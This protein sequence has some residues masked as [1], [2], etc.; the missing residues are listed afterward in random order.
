MISGIDGKLDKPRPV[1][2]LISTYGAAD[3]LLVCLKSLAKHVPADCR[4]YV[5][6]DATPNDSV[7]KT[8][9]AVQ[10]YFP[11]LSYHRSEV[12]RGI[13]RKL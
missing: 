1:S 6:D 7:R 13:R 11:Q 4:V 12:N 8:C 3:K 10:A 9:E 5:L 2:I